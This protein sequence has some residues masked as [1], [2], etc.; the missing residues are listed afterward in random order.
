MLATHIGRI[1]THHCQPAE[2]CRWQ[3]DLDPLR[4]AVAERSGTKNLFVQVLTKWSVYV[5]NGCLSCAVCCDAT[6][7][8]PG[9]QREAPLTHCLRVPFAQLARIALLTTHFLTSARLSTRQSPCVD[10]ASDPYS[11]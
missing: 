10:D 11:V 9:L 5:E 1:I 2:V 6:A 8:F 7:V 3:R 4:L